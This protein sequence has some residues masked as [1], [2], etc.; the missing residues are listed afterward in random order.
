[1]YT[2]TSKAVNVVNAGCSVFTRIVRTL[3]DVDA[4]R[5]SLKTYKITLQNN[6]M[7]H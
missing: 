2:G 5:C 6:T 4:T 3:V 1:M 7:T